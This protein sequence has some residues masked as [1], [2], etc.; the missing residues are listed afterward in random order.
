M[1][2]VILIHGINNEDRLDRP[3]SSQIIEQVWSERIK[4]TAESIDYPW[5]SNLTFRTAFYGDTLAHGADNWKGDFESATTMGPASNEDEYADPITAAL[6]REYQEAFGISD[7]DVWKELD[8]SDDLDH[9]EMAGGIH[10]KWLKAIARTL[11]KVIPTRGKYVARIALRQAAAYLQ[12]PGLKEHIDD[13]VMDQV[14]KDLPS[15][16][17]VIV[18]THSLGTIVGYDLLR[19]L[20]H[21]VK[22]DLFLTLGSPLGINIVK[23]RLGPPLVFPNSI[24]RWVNASDKEDFVALHTVLNRKTFGVDGIVNIT[25]IDNGYEDAHSILQYLGHTEVVREILGAV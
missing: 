18:V 4:R 8:S 21:S 24:K 19:R 22:P 1:T 10:K 3:N 2:T 13:M 16:E 14:F 17:K 23:S 11:E 7:E 20:R 12:R 25:S 6:F 15:D 5:P 9:V